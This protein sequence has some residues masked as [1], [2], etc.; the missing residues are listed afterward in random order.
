MDLFQAII[1]GIFQGIFEWLPVSSQGQIAAIAVSFFGIPAD[2]A[3]GY[4]IFLHIGTLIAAAAYFR[5]E[6]SEMALGK[7]RKARNFI[8]LAVVATGITAIPSYLLLKSIPLTGF[9]LLILIAVLLFVTGFLQKVKS[10]N[11][12]PELTKKNS[13]ILG[14]AQGFSVLPGISR[15]GV[16]TAAL[17]LEGFSPER[18]FR[19]S[20]LLSVPSVL[21]GEMAFSILEPITF[22]LSALVALLF[23]FAF[24][25][26]S[27][28]AL[29]NFARAIN[30]SLFCW[31][32]GILYLLIAFLSI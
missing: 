18:A 32:F 16:T 25:Y 11:T 26:L 14:L 3:L 4:A 7:D 8:L 24:G 22:D 28:A 17:L 19:I 31:A 5:K 9:A 10:K 12:N 6:L 30:F 29:L 13:V 15:S 23:A 2:E 1:L 21:I 27:I 20:F